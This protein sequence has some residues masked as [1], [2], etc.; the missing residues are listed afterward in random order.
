MYEIYINDRP[1]RLIATA[2]L[3][4]YAGPSPSQLVTRYSGK[5]KTLLNYADMLEK[6]SPKVQT[7]VLHYPSLQQLWEDF[8][9]HYK[10]ITA[11]G[12]IVQLQ[13]TD[14]LLFIYRRGYL[15]LPKG[16]IDPGETPEQAAIR[17]VQEETG[18]RSVSIVSPF[19]VKPANAQRSSAE[20]P[21]ASRSSPPNSPPAPPS[22]LGGP[23]LRSETSED[24]APQLPTTDYRLPTNPPSPQ[25]PTTDYRLPT[26]PPSPQL[27]TTDY[28]LPTNPPSP[29][30]KN[31]PTT[32]LH[33]YRTKKDKRI[34]KPTYWYPM[35]TSQKQLTPQTEEDIEWARWM[36]REVAI[37]GDWKIYAS[38]ERLL[39]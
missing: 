38:L 17:E 19:S 34:L 16:K 6:G 15:D 36:S 32:T 25:L 13:G 5:V 7:L 12:G 23:A 24:V 18:L 37:A 39:E 11:A 30:L 31:Y 29:Q 26:N 10:I 20:A 1:L 8:L 14:K 27:P 4:N 21:D 2:D 33:T 35:I 28:R 3:E 22:D 9:S